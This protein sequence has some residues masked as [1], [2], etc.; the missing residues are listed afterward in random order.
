MS[1]NLFC[2]VCNS[3]SRTIGDQIGRLDGRKFHM[4]HCDVCNYSYYDN[5]RTDWDMLYGERYYRGLGADP[6]V[7]YIYEFNNPQ[8]TIR[9][10]EWR[11]ILSLYHQ[12]AEGG[13][14]LDFGCG[15][16]GLVRFAIEAG[17]DAMGCDD[18]YAA[19]IGRES[20]LPILK[21][22]Q[23]K[24]YAGRYDFITAIEVIEHVPNPKFLFNQLRTLLK[25]GGKLFLTTGNAELWRNNLLKWSYTQCPDV[26]ISFYEPST[27]A[28][29]MKNSKMIP[30]NFD[31]M[32]DGFVEIIKYKVLKT[33]GI[34]NRSWLINILPWK[35]LAYIVNKRYRVNGHPYG[36]AVDA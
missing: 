36:V 7:D 1:V 27:T 11:G 9:Y 5:Y 8:K 21:T 15:A 26:H 32:S 30:Y 33:L 17:I 10:Y 14:W 6:M 29:L 23:L 4:L 18:G 22:C 24:D 12:L 35:L 25:P 3:L 16:G 13:V 31:Y 28:A 20:G 34:R 2:P 19:D